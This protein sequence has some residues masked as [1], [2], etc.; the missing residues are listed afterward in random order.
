MSYVTCMHQVALEFRCAY[1]NRMQW[2]PKTKF[3]IDEDRNQRDI[4]IQ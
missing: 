2:L 4:S 1:I 3:C